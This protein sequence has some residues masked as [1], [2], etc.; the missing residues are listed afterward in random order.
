MTASAGPALRGLHEEFGDQV[1]FVTVYVREAHPGE[2]YPQPEEMDRKIRHARDYREREDIGWTIVVDDVEGSLHRALDEKPNSA[3]LVDRDGTVLFRSLWSNDEAVLR[4]GLESVAA[5][6]RPEPG[7]REPR[8]KPML[9]GAG[10]M[11]R[12]LGMAGEEA[13]R[14]VRREVPPMYLMARTADLFRPL[15]PMT[16]TL[17]AGA[18]M[19]VALGVVI[20]AAAYAWRRD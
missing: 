4:E 5:G 14:D 18:V 12:I 16:R 9:T 19:G 15:P 2:R 3:Y 13:R 8:L 11:Y 17:A 10:E 7:E 1:R 6:G 20:G